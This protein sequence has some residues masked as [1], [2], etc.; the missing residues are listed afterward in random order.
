[1]DDGEPVRFSAV[2]REF[3]RVTD[4]DLWNGPGV[5]SYGAI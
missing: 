3:L 1:M 2:T 4:E 5:G